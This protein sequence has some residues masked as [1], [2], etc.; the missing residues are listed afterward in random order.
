MLLLRAFMNR[1]NTQY[2]W[3]IG[4]L[5]DASR[6]MVAKSSGNIMGHTQGMALG[7]TNILEAALRA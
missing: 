4:V 3:R 2:T 5:S 7:G 6:I 1:L